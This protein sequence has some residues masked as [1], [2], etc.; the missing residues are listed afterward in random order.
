ME[1]YHI[2]VVED[3]PS[4]LEFLIE[5]LQRE[6]FLVTSATDGKQSLEI[7]ATQKFDLLITDLVMSEV[8]GFELLTIIIANLKLNITLLVTL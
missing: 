8:S 7:L 2:L 3:E 6:G 1:K 4:I 5:L